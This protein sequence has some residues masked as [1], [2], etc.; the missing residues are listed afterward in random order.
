MCPPRCPVAP[1]RATV[2]RVVTWIVDDIMCLIYVVQRTR[3]M[4]QRKR[5]TCMFTITA[6]SGKL[7]PVRTASIKARRRLWLWQ[8]HGNCIGREQT[9]MKIHYQ[10]PPHCPSHK[11][12]SMHG[13][14]LFDHLDLLASATKS[15]VSRACQTSPWPELPANS[16]QQSHWSV[17]SLIQQSLELYQQ[18]RLN[19]FGDIARKDQAR[20]YR[21]S[22]A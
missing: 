5:T 8:R 9:T 17:A 15:D 12:F 3:E 22:C 18:A 11:G 1:A 4:Y 20:I 21:V 6:S 16:W 13:C 7:N 2:G 19:V 14:L 10:P